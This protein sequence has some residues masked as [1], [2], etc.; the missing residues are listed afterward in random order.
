MLEAGINDDRD[1][2]YKDD[3]D[4]MPKIEFKKKVKSPDDN[5]K[6]TDSDAMSDSVDEEAVEERK[7][8]LMKNYKGKKDGSTMK[9]LT[10]HD[11][12][13]SMVKNAWLSD[14]SSRDNNN[15]NPDDLP[16]R[17]SFQNA[18]LG[19]LGDDDDDEKNLSNL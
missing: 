12:D 9:V 8:S 16:S 2:L 4:I 10:K 19:R 13:N 18:N 6:D 7:G 11:T 5:N 14:V 17:L 3:S 1:Q 15:N